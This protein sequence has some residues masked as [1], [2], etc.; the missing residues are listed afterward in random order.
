MSETNKI[1]TILMLILQSAQG[2]GMSDERA[3]AIYEDIISH[4]RNLSGDPAALVNMISEAIH[5]DH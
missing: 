5:H 3:E 1:S 2:G 4:L